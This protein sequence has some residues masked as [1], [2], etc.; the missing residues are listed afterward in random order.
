MTSGG[1]SRPTAGCGPVTRKGKLLE[2]TPPDCTETLTGPAEVTRLAGIR[3]VSC[4]SLIVAGVS[5][6]P[7]QF[8]IEL[9][10]KLTP[11]MVSVNSPAPAR[12]I[13]LLSEPMVG[14]ALVKIG[15]ASW[16][17]GG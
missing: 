17:A 14:L 12:A 8:T 15:R 3:T 7:P 4:L 13:D 1:S 6:L 9:L 16:R 10:P 2:V 5:W 11:R